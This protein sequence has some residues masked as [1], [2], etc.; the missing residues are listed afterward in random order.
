MDH[1]PTTG[2]DDAT[3]AQAWAAGDEGGY[4]ALVNRYASLVYG[5][6]RRALGV[7]DADDATQAVFLVLARKRSQAAASPALAAWLMTVADFVIRNAR[8]DRGRLRHVAASERLADL[9]AP[10]PAMAD[11]KEHLDACLEQLPVAEREAVRLHHLAGHTLAEV[12]VHT[13]V[14]LS[15]VYDRVRRGLER[16]KPL[17]VRRGVQA[18]SITALLACLQAEAAA[19][20]PQQLMAGLRD[21]SPA[22]GGAGAT[23]AISDRA[24]RWSRP[25]MSPMSRLALAGSFALLVGGGLALALLGS[26]EPPPP[27]VAVST[28]P[29]PAPAPDF[30]FDPERAH[31]W[32]ALRWNDGARTAERL[33]RLP[34]AALVAGEAEEVFRQVANLR[35]AALLWDSDASAPR[36][37]VVKQYRLQHEMLRLTPEQQVARAAQVIDEQLRTAQKEPSAQ[38]FGLAT[39]LAATSGW[40]EVAD[41]A[42]LAPL[43]DGTLL[44]IRAEADGWSLRDGACRLTWAGNRL[45]AQGRNGPPAPALAASLAQSAAPEADFEMVQW[46]DTGLPGS[47]PIAGMVARM[48][49]QPEGLR[50][51]TTTSWQ[52][53]QDRAAAVDW[54]RLD[55]QRLEAVPAGAFLAC[56]IPLSSSHTTRSVFL[57]S[58]LLGMERLPTAAG[59]PTGPDG[60]ALRATPSSVTV[61]VQSSGI[62]TA[63]AAEVNPQR[64][65]GA[66]RQALGAVDGHIVA[67][68]EPGVPLPTVTVE[69]DLPQAAADA[70]IAATGE[71]RAADGSISSFTG[72]VTATLGWR[73]GRLIFTTV[74]GGLDAIDRRG[75]FPRHPEVQRAFDAMPDRQPNLAVILR[76]AALVET[77]A[78]FVAMAGP[79]WGQ[80]LEAYEQRLVADSA[81]AYFT[82]ASDAQGLRM[83]AA[84]LLALVAGAV[85]GANAQMRTAN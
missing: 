75:G 15:T 73:D 34:E 80:R 33:R 61:T 59:A 50:F 13:G 2:T 76:P 62:T 57:Q 30:D 52:R 71:P 56:A 22:G 26:A 85:M 42:A 82:V 28:D 72:M 7:A 84:G 9:P 1:E 54:P 31:G 51:A 64:L 29:P 53:E 83:D 36:E 10:E 60:V 77:V 78:P 70:L 39:V 18:A 63:G 46:F 27:A 19:A 21:L 5:R 12:A 79:E 23:A 32:M 20:V 45:E 40:L 44:D 58:I 14:P 68:V 69:V 43:P 17:L 55:R 11:I 48:T 6:C 3:L 38:T 66:I 8:R 65:V 81:Y 47:R 67:W 25:R 37:Q 41:R 74:P 49:V 24:L 4:T 35:R 16:M